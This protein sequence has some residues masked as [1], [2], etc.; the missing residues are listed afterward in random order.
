MNISDLHFKTLKLTIRACTFLY[1][2]YVD[3]SVDHEE[4]YG[5]SLF[6]ILT[7]IKMYYQMSN[8]QYKKTITQWFRT[9]NSHN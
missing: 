5:F 8:Y 4:F 2:I 7:K 3:L 6:Q 9:I 1:F